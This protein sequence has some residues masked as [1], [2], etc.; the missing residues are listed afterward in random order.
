M[1]ST[2]D[3]EYNR[4]RVLVQ[5]LVNNADNESRINTIGSP[6][7][8][9]VDT[10]EIRSACVLVWLLLFRKYALSGQAPACLIRML[11]SSLLHIIYYVHFVI[12]TVIWCLCFSTALYSPFLPHSPVLY[13]VYYLYCLPT[14][15]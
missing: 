14:V 9:D 15:Y 2:G 8:G 12:I 5:I 7:I 10:A 3:T 6:S 13:I 11:P 1:L 4:N